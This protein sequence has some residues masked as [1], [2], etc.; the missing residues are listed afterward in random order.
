MNRQVK[1][2]IFML[3]VLVLTLFAA[4][5][6]A[7]QGNS[8]NFRAHLRGGEEVPAVDTDAQG[9]VI[10]KFNKDG[11]LSYKLI[12]ANIENVRVAHIHC[13]VAGVNGPVGVTLY[14]GPT[15][16][17]N[18]VLAQATVT[19][20]DEGNGCGW[21]TIADVLAAAQA[22]GAYVNVHTDANP[23]GEIRGQLH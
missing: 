8:N 15:V 6:V 11:S 22:G 19:A 4:A 23:P 18:G 21:Q 17:T 9:Q 7:A 13:G 1:R 16:T 5:S 14:G 3:L 20:P 10:V 12:V 2:S